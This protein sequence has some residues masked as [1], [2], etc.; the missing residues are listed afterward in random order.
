MYCG[1]CEN[2]KKK[3]FF[4]RKDINI[5]Y[6]AET[7]VMGNALRRFVNPERII[8]G[9]D[10][11]TS[12]ISKFKK[13]KCPIFQY[14]LNQAEMVKMAIN[15]FLF[16]SVSYANMMDSYCR[17]FG[18]KFSDI[19]MS[20]KTDK[21]IGLKSYISPSLGIS[22]GHLE[23]DV[24]TLINSIKDPK[25]KK[26]FSYLRNFN[27]NRINELIKKY[28]LLVN[29]NNFKKVIWLGPSYK[30]NSFSIVNSPYLKFRNYLKKEVKNF[31][32]STLFLTLKMKK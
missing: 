19:N 32:L 21:R 7:L 3:I 29:K 8:L 4:N 5:I 14:N 18:F 31:L 17:Q 12:F 24:Y 15:L 16:K 25:I 28:N 27:Q 23:R 20:L 2:L 26:I 11:R 9:F 6:M 22:G 1:F 10:K 13:F 30:L